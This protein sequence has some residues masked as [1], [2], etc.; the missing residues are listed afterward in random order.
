MAAHCQQRAQSKASKNRVAATSAEM[1]DFGGF[2]LTQ[3]S[4]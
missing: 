1:A 2:V 3:R 4:D